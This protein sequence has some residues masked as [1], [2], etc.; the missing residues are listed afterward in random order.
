MPDG[1]TKVETGQECKSDQALKA[2]W[3]EAGKYWDER[4]AV[5]SNNEAFTDTF[6]AD[7]VTIAKGTEPKEGENPSF[8]IVKCNGEY[9]KTNAD[10]TEVAE[11]GKYSK[12]LFVVPA[13][14]YD[15]DNTKRL[16]RLILLRQMYGDA[17]TITDEEIT[18]AAAELG[19]TLTDPQLYRYDI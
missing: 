12:S 7:D 17:S 19:I 5:A 4:Y 8:R 16:Y 11:A 10:S 6:A 9:N 13:N 1:K 2:Q 3:V 15:N 14:T 18:Q